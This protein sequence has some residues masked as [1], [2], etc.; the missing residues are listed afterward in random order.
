MRNNIKQYKTKGKIFVEVNRTYVDE[1][2]LNEIVAQLTY[3]KG[4]IFSSN[5]E[6]PGRYSRWEIAFTEPCVEVR[7]FKRN[8]LIQ[9]LKVNGL[10]LINK[11]YEQFK[12]VLFVKVKEKSEVYFWLEVEESKE[13]FSEEQR[14]KQ[15]TVFSVI[16][17]IMN[18][19]HSDEDDKLGLYGAIG[20]DVV[21]QF[22]S[23]IK[24]CKE[25]LVTKVIDKTQ[26]KG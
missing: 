16:R 1:R 8:V 3:Q 18:I 13:V 22:E 24:L 14:S 10:P 23:D 4:G 26:K 12:E 15:N 5:Y 7:S 2:D 21:Y 17:E 25:R 19:C 6:Y 20:Y 9:A 11:M